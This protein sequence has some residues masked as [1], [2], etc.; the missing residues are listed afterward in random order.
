MAKK[1][2][3]NAAV[4]TEETKAKFREKLK[5]LLELGNKK[6]NILEYQE[7]SDFF[8]DMN[9]DEEKMEKV[10][11]FLEANKVD[12][13]RISDGD[14]EDDDIILDDEDEV[15]VEKIDLSVPE[16]VSVEDPVRM[17]LKEIGKVPLLSADEE[18]ELAQKMEAGSVAVEKIP[19]LKER[20]AE[21]GEEQEKEEIQAEIKALQLDVDRGSD[22]KKRLAEANLRLVVSIAK[23]YVGRGMLFLDLIQEGNLGLIKAV[24]KFDYRKGYKFSTYATW[25]IRQAITRAIADQAR[26]I[27]IPVH[28]VETI[29]KLIRVSRQLLQELGREPTPEEIAEE[30]KMPVERVRE[31]LKISQEPVSLETPIGEEE[32]SHL[33]DFIKDDNVPVPADAATFTLLKEQLEEVLGTLTEREQKVLTL[34]FGL[35]DGRARTLEEVGKEFNVTR[36][37]IRQI[38]AKA[39]RKLRHP[40]RSR[41][42]KDYL[43]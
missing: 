28:M 22:A 2:E 35:E 24:E 17:Y 7:I 31:I 29:N 10:L 12:V 30:M 20:L 9:L 23:R 26:T 25:W 14:D 33:G 11:D 43:E 1:K 8:R 34:R 39:L 41:K 37:R 16:G 5:S 13:L 15:E 36:E 21:T 38:E 42:L 4:E 19:L 40:S 6:R 3:E 32:D 18:I 27:R